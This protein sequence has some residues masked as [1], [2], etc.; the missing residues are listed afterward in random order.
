MDLPSKYNGT[1]TMRDINLR[2]QG[3]AKHAFSRRH[4][5]NHELGSCTRSNLV[6]E[7][8]RTL[9]GEPVQFSIDLTKIIVQHVK[10]VPQ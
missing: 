1:L 2:E 7:I 9:T 8:V 5:L 6:R 3:N 10:P 4:T